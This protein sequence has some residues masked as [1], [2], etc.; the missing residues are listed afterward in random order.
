MAPDATQPQNPYS[1]PNASPITEVYRSWGRSP[2][3]AI[4]GPGTMVRGGRNAV[5]DIPDPDAERHHH[6]SLGLCQRYGHSGPPT[7]S[8]MRVSFETIA[9]PAF[10]APQDRMI[11]ED[12]AGEPRSYRAYGAALLEPAYVEDGFG[13]PSGSPCDR[14][15]FSGWDQCRVTWAGVASECARDV[16]PGAAAT[17]GNP[18]GLTSTG[19]TRRT[20]R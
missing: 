15:R 10:G 8:D 17:V 12:A 7:D 6:V 3:A 16:E 14:S 13:E 20:A 4:V 5:H 19:E 1:M 11:G 18:P 9:V 2:P